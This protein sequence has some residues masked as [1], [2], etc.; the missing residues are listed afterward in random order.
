VDAI[1]LGDSE[2]AEKWMRRHTEQRREE[3][4]DLITL[5]SQMKEPRRAAN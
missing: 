1:V 2:E 3:M 4:D 5:M